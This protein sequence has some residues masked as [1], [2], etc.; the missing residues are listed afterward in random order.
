MPTDVLPR[1]CG[2]CGDEMNYTNKEKIWSL[3]YTDG[4]VQAR[5]A[6]LRLSEE[7]KIS[8]VCAKLI[9]N[10]GYRTA[11]KARE[12]LN[13]DI[14]MLHDPYLM[15]DMER[16]TERICRALEKNEKI[17]VYGDYDVDGVTSVSLLYLYLK[18]HGADIDY[19]IPSRNKEGYG[20]SVSAIDKLAQRGTELIITVDTGITAT[21][22][23]EYAKGLGIDTV[24]TDHH[25]CYASLPCADAVI[26]PHRP[27]CGYPFCDLAGV[28]VVFKLVCALEEY[29][30]PRCGKPEC[31]QRIVEKYIDLVAIGT[32]ADVMPLCDENRFIVDRGIRKIAVTDRTGLSALIEA[33]YLS[34]SNAQ[35][36]VGQSKQK[37]RKINTGFIGFTLAPRINAAGRISSAQKAVEL[38]LCEDMAEA[39]IKAQELCEINLCRQ[40]EE[41]RIAEQAY[42]MIEQSHNFDKDKVI[43][44][45]DDSWQQGIIGIVS[46]RITEKY[47]LPSI[48]ISY[49]GAT[50]GFAC[51]DDIGK[52]SGRSIKG[53]N[54]VNALNACEDLL[55][56]FGGHALAAGL[57]V[58]RGNVALFREK[59]NQY[60]SEHL[61]EEDI[62]VRY[63]AD[64]E[65]DISEATMDLVRGIDMLEPFGV[66]NSAPVF[67]IRNLEIDK[68]TSLGAGNHSKIF[69]M[70]E[71]QHINAVCF[72]VSASKLDFCRGDK[73]DILCQLSVNEFRG[74]KTLQ[75]IVQ[76][77]RIS[78][79]YMKSVNEG[80]KRYADILKGGQFSAS[81]NIIPSRDE[82]ATVYKLLRGELSTGH[83]LIS[84]RTLKS[85]ID[86][87]SDGS[88]GYVKLRFILDIINDMK[89][90]DITE[91]S[92]NIFEFQINQNARKTSIEASQT[93]KMLSS[94]CRE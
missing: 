2:D 76:D 8:P 94:G 53:L 6:V 1:Y 18:S 22:E 71:A 3:R 25:E 82:V 62:K 86:I 24:V 48:L 39:Q 64:C 7:L 63:E 55:E 72:G 60:V 66:A 61:T 15:K 70:G 44:L 47:G 36:A 40:I 91:V 41:N 81:E 17:T 5:E 69:F 32:V 87:S 9:Y 16:A 78:E 83:T 57:S 73:I 34:G 14:S 10:R 21:K 84:D 92:E 68:I 12:F 89:V 58:R 52:G 45:D 93:F 77:L 23:V 26:N 49:E 13:T 50:R 38:L 85:Y 33:S 90:M 56:K 37:R 42:K 28:G 59:F 74:T 4:D 19:Y 20:V 75:F 67:I 35:P 43:I 79:T 88:I 46:S 65:L 80:R 51:S 54:L 30:N 31:A 29:L 27:D 11:D